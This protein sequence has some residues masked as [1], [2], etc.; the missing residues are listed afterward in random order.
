MSTARQPRHIITISIAGI[1]V[2]LTTSDA[3]LAGRV[4][5]RYRD[6]LDAARSP[7]LTIHLTSAAGAP[8]IQ[9]RPGPWVIETAYDGDRLRYRSYL[10]QGE[11]DFGRGV[12]EVELA[13]NATIENVLRAVYAWLCVQDGSLL[14]H[15]AGVVRD[16]GGFVFFGP[17]G[18]GKTTT[19]RIAARTAEVVSDDL[20]VVR[21][22]SDG[23]WL[24]GV[25]FRGTL[26]D[27]PRANQSAPLEGLFRLRQDTAH[28]VKPIGR[29]EAIADLAAAAPFIVREKSLSGLLI[30]VAARL[31]AEVPV[32]ELHFKRD[33]GFWTAIDRYHAEVPAAASPDGRP[34]Y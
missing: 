27:A 1:A 20:V 22:G 29:A 13:P 30:G 21:R 12:G 18:A 23:F 24:H 7:E 3:A 16:G 33:D 26:S 14:L 31:A 9:P 6:F 19:A 15:A 11:I 28:F 25:P 5:A 4:A 34:G 8:F 32:L 10:E 2:A 17:S